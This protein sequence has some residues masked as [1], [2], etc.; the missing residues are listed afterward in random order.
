[1]SFVADIGASA[2][3]IEAIE[4]IFKRVPADTGAAF[5]TVTHFSPDR[6]SLLHEVVRLP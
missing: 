2:G 1:M 6:E 4:G 5:I 3:G